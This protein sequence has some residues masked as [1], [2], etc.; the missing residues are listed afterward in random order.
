M[1]SNK[2]GLETVMGKHGPSEMN[3]NGKMFADFC[4]FNKLVIGGSAFPHK[5]ACSLVSP[6]SRTE[7]QINHVCALSTAGCQ[8]KERG[9]CSF[10]PPPS[11]G[12][13]PFDAEEI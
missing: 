3:D 11:Y 4:S 13:T 8:S 10:R 2:S 7:N 5:K 9:R 6:E 12:Q 1:G